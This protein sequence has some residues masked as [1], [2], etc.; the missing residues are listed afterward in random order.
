MTANLIILCVITVNITMPKQKHYQKKN[1]VSRNSVLRGDERE[2][3][4]Y[5]WYDNDRL[6]SSQHTSS[7][8]VLSKMGQ[9]NIPRT[10]TNNLTIIILY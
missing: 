3:S 4:M 1:S 9:E 2:K 5:C 8:F 7:W 6:G 10:N